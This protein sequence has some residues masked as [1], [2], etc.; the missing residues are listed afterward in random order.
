M[1]GAT[2]RK[3]TR[4]F[5]PEGCG[6]LCRAA[7]AD[8]AGSHGGNVGGC[9]LRQ[10]LIGFAA[11]DAEHGTRIGYIDGKV[12]VGLHGLGDCG[13]RIGDLIVR[14]D[15]QKFI[16]RHPRRAKRAVLHDTAGGGHGHAGGS[17]DGFRQGFDV[18]L[19]TQGDHAKG[20]DLA[21]VGKAGIAGVVQGADGIRHSA[22]RLPCHRTP[23]RQCAL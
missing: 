20:A 12:V 1:Y 22:A 9:Q 15:E 10:H 21:D 16:W 11:R 18:M 8:F 13:Q 17:L 6:N 23:D 2:D 14:H 3:H 19:A 5:G 7:A 4:V